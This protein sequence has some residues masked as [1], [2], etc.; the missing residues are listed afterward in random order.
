M[1]MP[2]HLTFTHVERAITVDIPR[3][4][5]ERS[6]GGSRKAGD[7]FSFSHH[8]DLGFGLLDF[9]LGLHDHDHDDDDTHRQ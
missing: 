2:I 8:G 4:D 6:M 7:F 9:R 5:L 3:D 1:D